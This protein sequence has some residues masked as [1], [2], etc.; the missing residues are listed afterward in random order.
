[1]AR[2]RTGLLH[3]LRPCRAQASIPHWHLIGT[4]C[5]EIGEDCSKGLKPETTVNEPS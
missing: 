3:S 5:F 2:A 1:M 4:N